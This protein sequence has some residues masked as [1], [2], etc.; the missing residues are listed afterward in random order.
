MNLGNIYHRLTRISAYYPDAGSRLFI[1]I[2]LFIFNL[3]YIFA[4]TEQ[5]E[6][7]LEEFDYLE[8]FSDPAHLWSNA[9][10]RLMEEAY[11]QCFRTKIIGGRVM[12]IRLPFAM[13]NDRDI[14]LESKMQIT[15]EGKA[16]PAILWPVIEEILESEKFEEYIKALSS[17]REKVFIFDMVSRQWSA[18]NDLFLIARI[19]GGTYKG[20]PHRPYVLTS[21]RG[22]LES[23]VYN[24]L[25]CIGLVGIDCSGFVWHILSYLAKHGGLD[26]GRTLSPALGVPRGA[27]PALYA[28]TVFFSSRSSQII[29][30]DDEIR[31]LRPAD[32]MLFRDIDGTIIH[33]AVIQSI[34]MTRGRIR[35]LQCTNV[36]LPHER[37][38]H[39]SFIYFDPANTAVSLKDPSLHWSKR[40]YPAFSGEEI[41]F[42]D[43]GERYRHRTGGGGRIVRLRALVPVV[44]RLSR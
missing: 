37:G 41:P 33:S 14:L 32:I 16:Q 19:K 1:V 28:G 23:D 42:I 5:M 25:Y 10:E 35:Y 2:I 31:N 12:N 29:S 34:D 36:G 20:L 15:G 22:A 26:L 43:D 39:D 13:N 17:G 30:V 8:S 9:A 21:G 4:Q 40:R 38:V 24:Y 11:R 44:E 3:Q 6:P 7:E 27:D 18:S